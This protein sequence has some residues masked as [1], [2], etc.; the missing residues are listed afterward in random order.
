[1]ELKVATMAE[2]LTELGKCW[3]KSRTDLGL[4]IELGVEP[5]ARECSPS[6]YSRLGP[7]PPKHLG[8]KG[9]HIP[10]KEEA[11]CTIKV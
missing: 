6:F 3:P 11:R 7:L 9:C 8:G 1:M 10:T 5:F 4:E 2:T